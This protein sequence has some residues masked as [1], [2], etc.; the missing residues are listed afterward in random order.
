MVMSEKIKR[1]STFYVG[2]AYAMSTW[3]L[4]PWGWNWIE[5]SRERVS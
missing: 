1:I 2:D 3:S 4:K 5:L